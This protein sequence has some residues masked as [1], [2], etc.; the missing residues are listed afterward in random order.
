VHHLARSRS[1]DEV[2]EI[3]VTAAAGAASARRAATLAVLHAR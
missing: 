3:I 2:L 1:E